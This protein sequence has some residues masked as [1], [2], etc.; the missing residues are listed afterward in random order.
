MHKDMRTRTEVIGENA[1]S[2]FQP[3]GGRAKGQMMVENNNK[4]KK[5]IK[6]DICDQKMMCGKIGKTDRSDLVARAT[7]KSRW[8]KPRIHAIGNN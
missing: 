5:N 1:R 8:S 7:D 6:E 3:S 4:G 2:L